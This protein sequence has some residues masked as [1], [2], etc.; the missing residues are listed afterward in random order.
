MDNKLSSEYIIGIMLYTFSL[1]M[2]NVGIVT[3]ATNRY[4]QDA[5]NS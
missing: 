5:Y 3:L 4:D 1:E 2:F